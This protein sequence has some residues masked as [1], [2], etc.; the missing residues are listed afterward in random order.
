MIR[1]NQR[2][3]IPA[4]L[5]PY[6]GYALAGLAVVAILGFFIG[7]YNDG[8]RDEATKPLKQQITQMES[9]IERNKKDAAAQIKKREDENAAEKERHKQEKLANEK[10][11][12]LRLAEVRKYRNSAGGVR[13]NTGCGAGSSPAGQAATGSTEAP[14]VASSGQGTSDAPREF[15]ID[16]SAVAT[17]LEWYAYGLSCHA[18]V[19]SK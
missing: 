18:F 17:V 10:D 7:K 5:I 14:K 19:N 12:E 4:F 8:I 3:F 13:L 2:G 16:E 15:I 6:I 11:F 9:D 1:S